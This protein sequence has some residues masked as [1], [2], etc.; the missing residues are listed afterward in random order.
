MQNDGCLGGS[1]WEEALSLQ[2][3]LCEVPQ[4][5]R[6]PRKERIFVLSIA[7]LFVSRS[8]AGDH[9]RKDGQS[10]GATI[11]FRDRLL[12]V[13]FG[14]ATVKGEKGFKERLEAWR[15]FENCNAKEKEGKGALMM[16]MRVR[17][18]IVRYLCR[19]SCS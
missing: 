18:S 16:Q 15:T 10:R 6:S 1:V 3:G 9:Q 14:D 11:E 17:V 19:S 12:Q 13:F 7:P 8:L 5:S 4:D 2:L